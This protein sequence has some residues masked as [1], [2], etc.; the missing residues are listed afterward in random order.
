MSKAKKAY[1]DEAYAIKG[2]RKSPL[3]TLTYLSCKLKR[4]GISGHQI[5]FDLLSPENK[6]L[7][8]GCGEGLFAFNVKNKF[9][10]VYGTDISEVAIRNAKKAT[11]KREDK[12]SFHFLVHD[13][14]EG[15]PFEDSFF[16]AVTCM[17]VLEHVIHPP[18]LL[19]E[20]KRVL[21]NK[22]ELVIL[23]P[24]DAWLPY[25]TQYLI[26]KIPQSGG[27]NELGVDW[28]HLHKFNKRLASES[29]ESIGYYIDQITCSG[30]FAQ[31]RRR[32]LSLLAGNIIIKAIKH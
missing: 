18:S 4:F 28:G 17:A 6:I 13:I 29:L 7:D 1:Y 14:D 32:W 20:I 16:D 12:D 24:N 2:I 26:G 3:P 25:R 31:F 10:E 22:G 19:K 30:I 21:K 27:V 15:L 5:A 23:V 9:N 8:I 11:F